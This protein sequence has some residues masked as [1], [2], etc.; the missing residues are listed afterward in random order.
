MIAGIIS[1]FQNCSLQ[2]RK[3]QKGFYV[4]TQKHRT[5]SK[6]IE[7]LNTDLTIKGTV[8]ESEEPVNEL[9]ASTL[10]NLIVE[11]DKTNKV[12]LFEAKDSIP[13]PLSCNDTIILV[14]STKILVHIIDYSRD[15]ITYKKCDY[16]NK[17][18]N[19]IS[20]SSVS[21]IALAN[22]NSIQFNPLMQE[23]VEPPMSKGGRR[24]MRF[25]YFLLFLFGLGLIVLGF[26]NGDLEAVLLLIP[27][28][29]CAILIALSA[30][31]E[32]K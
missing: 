25:L 9:S 16:Y 19:Q 23:L 32:K 21:S 17:S 29:V 6:D 10:K 30:L 11:H 28:G 18:V 24:K 8:I 14:N 1:L 22:G 15:I 31:F 27:S 3:Y 7:K 26:V 20:K 13:L 12:N 5:S 4:S 2:K